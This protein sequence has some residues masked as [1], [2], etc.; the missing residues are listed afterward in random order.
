MPR[1]TGGEDRKMTMKRTVMTCGLVLLAGCSSSSSGGSPGDDGSAD[2]GSGNDGSGQD[3]T[4]TPDTGGNDAP[5]EATSPD[6]SDAAHADATDGGGGGDADATTDGSDGSP[7]GPTEGSTPEGSADGSCPTTWLDTPTVPATIMPDAGA[8]FLHAF[9]NGTQDYSCIGTAIDGGA[10]AGD[11]GATFTWTLVTPDAVLSDCH[12]NVIGH[13]AASAAGATAPEWLYFSDGTYVVGHKVSS[14]VPDGGS[15]SIPWLLIQA[16][17]HGNVDGGVDGSAGVLSD[18]TYIQRLDTEAGLA[19]S[20]GCDF[21]T[22]DASTNVP[23]TADY[24][25]YG[26]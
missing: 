26:P 14:Y 24:Y 3:G 16:T 17:A 25:F 6:A 2:D 1:L 8:V 19:P 7:D 22:A 13:H 9:G 15:G 12:G 4:T 11:A 18:V 23:Y 21:S 10:D 5:S 20:T